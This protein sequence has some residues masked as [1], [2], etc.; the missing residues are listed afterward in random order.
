M[1]CPGRHTLSGLLTGGGAQ[2]RDWT[3][4]YRLFS[5]SRLDPQALFRV[6]LQESLAQLPD[7]DQPIVA[8]MDDTLL[9]KTG[10][11]IPGSRWR[12]DPLGPPFHTNFIWSQ[13]FGQLSLALPAGKGPGPSRAIPVDFYHAPGLGRPGKKAGPEH[14]GFWREHKD[15][16]NLSRVGIRRV[17]LLRER[18]D[19]LGASTR[20]LLLSVDGGYTNERVLKALPER[21]TLIGRLRKDARL[22]R[23][24][25]A[26][27]DTGRRRVYGEPLPTP[28]QIRTGQGY[29]W[30][31][32]RGWAAGR[33]H[34]F[35]IK[36]V[37]GIRWRKAGGEKLLQLLIIRPLGYRLSKNSRML[38]RQ[39]AYLICTDANLSAQSLLQAYLWRWEIE[40]NFREE[41]TLMGCGQAQVRHPQSVER[42]P[43]FLVGIYSFLLLGAERTRTDPAQVLLPRPKWY[44]RQHSSRPT[45]GDLLGQFRA[46]AWA[47]S[48]G[49]SFSAFVNHHL[50]TTKS[51]KHVNPIVSAFTYMRN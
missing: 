21:V 24:A 49:L 33:R 2:F 5:Q 51:Q 6:A 50:R 36:R 22:Y 19:E 18:L 20:E 28:E 40:V 48:T 34:T 13:R 30:R 39:P 11:K 8:H 15:E 9:G 43:A 1:H 46:E 10:K 35:Y 4:A 31:E 17:G 44:P 3:S 27:P 45:T 7:P 37:Q 26:Q 42:V 32:L 47:E 41:K 29:S 23:P 12:R 14:W 38:Y 25:E 16:L